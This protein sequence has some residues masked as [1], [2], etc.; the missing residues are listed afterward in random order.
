MKL[1]VEWL[2]EF[3]EYGCSVDDL[4]MALT[5]AGLEV[6]EIITY[7]PEQLAH[8]GGGLDAP[9]GPVFDIKIT[10]NRG[11]CLSVTGISR[12]IAAVLD[13]SFKTQ[14]PTAAGS[15]PPTS[16]AIEVS[17]TAPDLCRRYSAGIVRN[18]KIKE[19]PSWLKNR[20]LMAGM[21]PINNVVDI[22]NYVMLEYGQPLHAFD[23]TLIKGA[24]IIVRRANPGEVMATI[25]GEERKLAE[26]MLVIADKE[27]AVAVAGV[28]GGMDTEVSE[29]ARTIL[30]ESASFDPVSIRRTS[31]KLSL[32]TESS[33][34]FER[35]V[36]PA[37]TVAA[38]KRAAE[39]MRDLADGEIAE[40]IV[41][42]YPTEIKPLSLTLRSERV[43]KLL[44]SSIETGEMARLLQLLGIEIN[45]S[46]DTLSDTFQAT[47]PTFRSDITEEIDLVEEIARLHGFDKIK[48]TLPSSPSQGRQADVSVFEDSLKQLLMRC[49]A[50]E[51][52]THSIVDTSLVERTGFDGRVVAIRNPLREDL[53]RLRVMLI[54]NLLEVFARNAA[55][56]ARDLAIFEIGRIYQYDENRSITQE[57][58]VA[59]A[60]IGT[61]WASAWNIDKSTLN[62]DFYL[63]KGVVESLLSSLGISGCEF[64]P[65]KSPLLHPT[66]SAVVTNSGVNIGIVGE[67]APALRESFDLRGRPYVFELNFEALR[68]LA[69]KTKIYRPVARYPAIYRDLSIV[70]DDGV[71]FTRVR[72]V[73]LETGGELIESIDLREV[74]SGAPLN[75]GQKS[76]LLSLAFR[77][78]ERTLTD[79]TVI[80][81]MDRIKD[82]L[83][84]ELKASIRGA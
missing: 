28:M 63:C 1:P 79:Q 29:S 82:G 38:L 46:G 49:G 32:S 14:E 21:R 59:G 78:T 22:T 56:G 77:S 20:L 18:V 34:R 40:G 67:V 37:V 65:A 7:S 57:R 64:T 27:R 71:P 24:E 42:A 80:D 52:M 10:P 9:A 12:E 51:V 43:N 26:D 36:D 84:R 62:A 66:R 6:E 70:L 25:D 81:Q 68:S 39:L 15:P 41:D 23:Y 35:G 17:I 61:Q 48:T 45:T 73:I 53:S 11:D 4:A 47:V 8:L 13:K 31:K 54:P 2:N 16:S 30:I 60:M 75:P 19:S 74:Y 44:G 69:A 76:F 58:S 5:M 3:V 72:Q 50:Q 33:Y 55:F 83:L